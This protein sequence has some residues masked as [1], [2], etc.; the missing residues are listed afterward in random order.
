MVGKWLLTIRGGMNLITVVH[1]KI[2]T[3]K[4]ILHKRSRVYRFMPASVGTQVLINPRLIFFWQ[5]HNL[6]DG[7]FERWWFSKCLFLLLG[8]WL[9]TKT[10]TQNRKQNPSVVTNS[11]INRQHLFHP[12]GVKVSSAA[13]SSGEFSSYYAFPC[14][15][16][17]LA[18]SA[19]A[20][21][22]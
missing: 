13:W 10:K 14:S 19:S 4:I 9:K 12:W 1:Q 22:A 15:V 2:E 18:F 21:S 6:P 20:P 17:I 3:W 7:K 5:R 8:Q 16:A 11:S